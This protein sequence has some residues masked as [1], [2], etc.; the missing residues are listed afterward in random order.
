MGAIDTPTS[1][2]VLIDGTA[3]SGLGLAAAAALRRK[4]LGF[5]F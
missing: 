2:R 5:V 1:G 4:H 3:T